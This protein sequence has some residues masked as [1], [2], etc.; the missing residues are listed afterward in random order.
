[1]SSSASSVGRRFLTLGVGEVSSR[2][3]AFVASVYVARTLGASV[4]GVVAAATTVMLYLA[5]VADCGI[6]MLG[7]REVAEHP[8]A[9][10]ETLPPI[11][12]ARLLVSAALIAITVPAA[13]LLLPKPDGP[14][15]AV[16]SVTLITVALGT[17]WVHLGLEQAANAS[18]ARVLNEVTAAACVLLFVHTPADLLRVPMAQVIGETLGAIFLFRTLP[19]AVRTFRIEL[20]PGVITP[21]LRRSWTVVLHGLL[22]L[23]IF[24]SDFL[25]LRTMQGS[26]AVGYY[27]AAYTLISFSQNLGV[28]YTM[29]L[30]PSI[31]RV[32]T[33]AVATRALFDGAM[34][35]VMAGGLPVAIGGVLVAGP[36]VALIYGAGYAASVRP[37][38]LLLLVIP[39]ALL[40]NVAQGVL[41]ANERPDLMLRTAAWAAGA[42]VLLNVLLIPRWGMEGA[43]V[44]TLATEGGRTILALRYSAQLGLPMTPVRR[45]VKI[46]LAATV[47]GGCV[48]LVADRSVFVS[49]PVGVVAY[50]GVLLALGIIRWRGGAMPVITL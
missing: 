49:I 36:L 7:V 10:P 27:A 50:V 20:R 45:F 25:F 33:D 14:V 34:A 9:L 42:N 47:M 37:L 46:M 44:A 11:L 38:Q 5:F 16:Y 12:G 17:R 41:L 26:E 2:L 48:Y 18:W 43:A 31:T 8:A 22:G 13:L 39:V 30:I 21:L 23:A 35:Q 1:M 6:D 24:N 3:F 15:L 40:R 19:A 32:R 28:A 29:S 4:Y